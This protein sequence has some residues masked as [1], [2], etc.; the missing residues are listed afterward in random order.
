MVLVSSLLMVDNVSLVERT[1]TPLSK[2]LVLA[3]LVVLALKLLITCVNDATPVSSLLTRDLVSLVLLES[4]T[5][6]LVPPNVIPVVVVDKSLRVPPVLAQVASSAKLASSLPTM[7][8]VRSVL[9]EQFPVLVHALVKLVLRD[10]VPTT[11]IPLPSVFCALL[12]PILMVLDLVK[13]VPLV[14]YP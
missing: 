14:L 10:M 4:T 2:E 1:P 11:L 5:L 8:H 13:L 9:K 3:S 7:V 6:N 12:E